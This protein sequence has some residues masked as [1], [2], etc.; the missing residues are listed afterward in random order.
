MNTSQVIGDWL[1]ADY[2]GQGPSMKGYVWSFEYLQ[3]RPFGWQPDLEHGPEDRGFRSFQFGTC[4]WGF[5]CLRVA[6]K[7]CPPN[8]YLLTRIERHKSAP[9]RQPLTG[10]VQ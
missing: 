7:D 9:I 5:N 3:C 4:F 6:S 1:D 2:A 10:V 8:Y